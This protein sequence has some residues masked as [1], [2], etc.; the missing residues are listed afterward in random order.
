MSATV[1]G[2][3]GEEPRA[4]VLDA[5]VAQL[6]EIATGLQRLLDVQVARARVEVRE[7]A[8]RALGWVAVTAFLMVLSGLAGFYLLR[9][10]AGL[11]TAALGR[12]WAGDLAAAFAAL[13]V[14]LVTGMVLRSRLRLSGLRRMRK[15]FPDDATR[16]AESE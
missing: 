9:G 13:A 4:D 8:F 15:K 12:P 3:S 16:R 6:T 10:L 14:A 1:P 11:L 7:K 2:P 5:V